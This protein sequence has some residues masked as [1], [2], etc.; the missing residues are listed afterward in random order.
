MAGSNS[1]GIDHQVPRGEGHKFAAMIRI[2][3]PWIPAFAAAA[4]DTM[5]T[6]Q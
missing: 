2:A 6:S 5:M 1:R 4:V 3:H